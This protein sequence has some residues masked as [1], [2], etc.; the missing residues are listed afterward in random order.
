MQLT[1]KQK[2]IAGGSLLA[3]AGVGGFILYKSKKGA[4]KRKSEKEMKKYDQAKVGNINVREVARQIGIDLGYAYDWYDPRR[5]TENDDAVLAVLQKFPPDLIPMLR[6]QYSD[7]Y[8]GR[9]LQ[10]D[11]QKVLDEYVKIKYLFI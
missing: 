4:N 7:L 11:L 3:L 6:Q 10:A 9:D 5:A 8:D 2:Y 1:T